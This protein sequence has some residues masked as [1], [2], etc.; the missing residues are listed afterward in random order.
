MWIRFINPF[1]WRPR[2]G[3]IVSYKPGQEASVTHD[4]G[5]AAVS[6]GYAVKLKSPTR[7]EA[8]AKK[9]GTETSKNLKVEI[10]DGPEGATDR[11]GQSDQDA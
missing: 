9:T 3:V 1:D 5:E 2:M 4:C 10:D 6:G 11:A 8:K 7:A